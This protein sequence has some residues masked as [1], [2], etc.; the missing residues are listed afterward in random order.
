[1]ASQQIYQTNIRQPVA[2]GEL[3]QK[4]DTLSWALFFI[5]I[6]VAVLVDVGWGWG[7]LGVAAIILGGAAIRR[8][9]ELPIE[10]FWIVVG[11]M[12]LVGG[13]WELFRVPWP[14]APILIIGCGLAMLWGIY[15]GRPLMKK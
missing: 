11:V 15:T 4:L 14:L 5:W 12:F 7:S 1:M 2:P 6:G 13:L 3:A 9:K 10:G 8:F